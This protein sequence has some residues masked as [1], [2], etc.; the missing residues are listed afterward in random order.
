MQKI[1]A[2]KMGADDIWMTTVIFSTIVI[3]LKVASY[4]QNPNN[5]LK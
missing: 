4:T 2:A 5:M 3:L 1:L